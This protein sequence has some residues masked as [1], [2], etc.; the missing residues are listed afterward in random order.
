M[1]GLIHERADD[2]LHAHS[3]RTFYEDYVTFSYVSQ[4]FI[5]R[6]RSVIFFILSNVLL[7]QSRIKRSFSHGTGAETNRNENVRA[8]S[9]AFAHLTMRIA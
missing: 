6:A 8:C 5:G 1:G 7:L 2:T 3:L 4:K 9:R